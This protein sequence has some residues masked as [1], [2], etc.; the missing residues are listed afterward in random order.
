MTGPRVTVLDLFDAAL[1][2]LGVVA[3]C[4]Y[5][6]LDV[7]DP[8]SKLLEQDGDGRRCADRQACLRRQE[9]GG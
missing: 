6:G 4:R 8:D 5:C 9:I 3:V 1:V 7:R 2:E